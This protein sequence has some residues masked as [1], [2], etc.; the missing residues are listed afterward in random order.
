MEKIKNKQNKV[1]KTLFKQFVF[2][3][4]L[5]KLWTIFALEVIFENSQGL[6]LIE[7][8]TKLFSSMSAWL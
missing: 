4:I 5:L 6:W 3:K 8:F 7:I 2:F 1:E